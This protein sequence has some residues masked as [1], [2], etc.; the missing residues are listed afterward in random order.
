MGFL[1]MSFNAMTRKLAIAQE[2]AQRSQLEVERQRAYLETVLGSISSGVLTLQRDGCVRTAN[3]AAARTL[4]TTRRQLTGQPLGS[5]AASDPRFL[6]LVGVIQ[7]NLDRDRWEEQVLLSGGGRQVLICRGSRL[8]EDQGMV[9]V[10]D[11]M[12]ALVRAERNAAWADV[13]RRLAHEIKNP[14]T[15]IQLAAERLR[16]KYLGTVAPEMAGVLDRSTH[17]IIQQVQALKQMVDAFNEYARP[18]QLQLGTVNIAS[19]IAEV[20]Y[21]YRDNPEGVELAER[22]PD[23]ELRVEADAGRLRQLLHNLVKNAVEAVRDGGG[24]R[25]EVAACPRRAERGDYLEITVSDDGPGLPRE[26]DIDIFEPYVSNKAK[27]SGLGLAISKK[28]V[29]EHGGEIHAED[30]ALGGARLVV[31]LPL[32]SAPNEEIL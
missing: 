6:A 29:E 22:V 11:D 14:L 32:N 1:V 28:I 10:F 16:R 7:R 21:L 19:L 24:H 2:D 13:A 26:A 18:P 30:G 27:G 3:L 31:R 8:T 17:T 5:I 9:L 4:G 12:T 15:P 25:V 23:R 20:L